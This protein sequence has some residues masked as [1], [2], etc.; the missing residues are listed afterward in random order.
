MKAIVIHNYGPPD[1]L[2]YENV[3]DPEPRAGEIRIRIHA[4]TVNRV[5][6]VSLRAGN[7]RARGPVLPLIPASIAPASSMRSDP[8]SRAGERACGSPPP[9]SCRSIFAARRTTTTPG[10]PA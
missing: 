3:P 4:A 8:G 10:P 9:A 7:E 2:K 6:D 5:L 1:V